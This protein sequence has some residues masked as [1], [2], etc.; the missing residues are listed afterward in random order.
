MT[1][2]QSPASWVR[3]GGSSHSGWSCPCPAGAPLLTAAGKL[4]RTCVGAV[5]QFALPLFDINSLD[6][7][8][9]LPLH[10]LPYV[11]HRQL[12]KPQMYE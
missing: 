7:T 10:V 1:W 11:Y 3:T 2:E 12:L 8:R 6:A 9:G 5:S 4:H